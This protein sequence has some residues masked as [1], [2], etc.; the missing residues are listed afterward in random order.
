MVMSFL[1]NSLLYSSLV[2]DTSSLTVK[3]SFQNYWI[4]DMLILLLIIINRLLQFLIMQNDYAPKL[5]RTY[6]EVLLHIITF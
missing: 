6:V 2:D 4:S 3:I 5:Y 1:S